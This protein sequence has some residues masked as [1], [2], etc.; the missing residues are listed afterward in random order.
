MDHRL[1]IAG[2]RDHHG[3]I[4]ALLGFE[5]GDCELLGV[6]DR[7]CPHL[8]PFALIETNVSVVA[9]RLRVDDGVHHIPPF[10]SP[11]FSLTTTPILTESAFV[12]RQITDN[13]I[14]TSSPT[15]ITTA[16]TVA[17]GAAV[18]G[19]AGIVRGIA[20]GGSAFVN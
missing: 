1:F 3:N 11:I 19:A 10:E 5:V 9:F 8:D 18:T 15:R 2:L 14:P 13:L 7:L 20:G 16:A 6:V 4:P 12:T 17:A